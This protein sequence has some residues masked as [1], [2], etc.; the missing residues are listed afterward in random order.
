[1]L[2]M[3]T[4]TSNNQCIQT[5]TDNRNDNCYKMF[6][7]RKQESKE[8]GTWNNLST[9]LNN[10]KTIINKKEEKIKELRNELKKRIIW[11]RQT[12]QIYYNIT[13]GMP[14]TT[15][16]V[17]LKG[18]WLMLGFIWVKL[19]NLKPKSS[20]S[21]KNRRFGGQQRLAPFICLQVRKP[22]KQHTVYLQTTYSKYFNHKTK[23][24]IAT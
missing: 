23:K 3:T 12:Y 24:S 20:F 18:Y 8:T 6:R 9:E 7:G 13:G 21:K 14:M 5:T 1:M 16:G 19:K 2:N 22:T 17:C 15:S 11:T 4:I 10:L